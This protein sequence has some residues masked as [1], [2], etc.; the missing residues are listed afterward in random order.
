VLEEYGD[1]TTDPDVNN[2]VEEIVEE[3]L[4]SP[5]PNPSPPAPGTDATLSTLVLSSGTLVPSFAS[6][7]INY[8]AQVDYSTTDLTVTPT[9]S[10]SK[11]SIKVNNVTVASGSTSAAINLNTGANIITIV[12]TAEDGTTT[13]TYK[14]TV[15]REEST[16]IEE[17]WFV[18]DDDPAFDDY[19]DGD[20][21]STLHTV[22]LTVPYRTDITDLKAGF[23]LSHGA[24]A[25]VSG[26]PQ[27][28][29]VTS[30]NFASPVTYTI[31]AR[32]ALPLRT[33]P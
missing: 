32:T 5:S 30:N 17:F 2:L 33:G 27:E 21:D 9:T 16:D 11:A 24:S 22:S 20:I 15:T 19:I 7:T 31:T 18:E 23:E 10:D 3:V 6:A 8:T 26:T 14:L 4:T 12:V 28:S 1:V 13:K 29:E 25:T